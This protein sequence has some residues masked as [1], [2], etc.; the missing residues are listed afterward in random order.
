MPGRSLRCEVTV[1][2]SLLELR[3]ITKRFPG[4]LAN[5]HVDLTVEPGEI[6]ALVGENGAGKSTLMRILYGLYQPDEGTILFR[7]REVKI[8]TPR[9]AIELGLGMVHQH[10]MLFPS[11]SVLEN[12]MF[13]S[14]PVRRGFIDIRVA[15]EKVRELCQVYGFDLDL[16]A[17]LRDLSVGTQQRVEILKMLYRSAD[18]LILDE[19]SAVLTPQETTQLFAVLKTLVEHGK[20]I[21]FI[22]H[23]LN[24]VM[25]ISQKVTVMRA[26]KVTGCRRTGETNEKELARL[27]VGREVL[28]EVV[29]APVT[30]GKP[31]LQV[32]DVYVKDDRGVMKVNGVTLDVHE[33]EILGVA[34]VDGNGQTELVEAICGLRRVTSG[35]VYIK[36]EN[37]TRASPRHRRELGIC[38]IPE[39]RYKRGFAEGGTIAENMIMGVHHKPPVSHG[40]SIRWKTVAS[41][42]ERLLRDFDVRASDVRTEAG[43]L[44][45]GNLQKMIVARELSRGSRIIIAAQPTRGIDIG[46][47]EYIRKLLIQRRDDGAGILLFSTEL[48]EVLSLSDRVVVMYNGRVVAEVQP[49]DTT[50][51]QVGL[52]MTGA[53]SCLPVS[54]G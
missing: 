39:D 26:G 12:I 9:K 51:E 18:L 19:P 45:G 30:P 41:Q 6:H 2:V 31:L 38:H 1:A 44:S 48:E 5:D 16:S 43:T 34:G 53:A 42:S 29:K 15:T 32:K 52:Y 25:A 47:I 24:E 10:F 33:N 35:A 49:H 40:Q 8:T 37:V 21:V 13:G 28:L 22:T 7:G 46:A 27:M 3:G 50:P 11:L 20:S 54:R 36:G 4:V 14:E 17:K 23:K